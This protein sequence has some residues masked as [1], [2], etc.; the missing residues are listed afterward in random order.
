[1]Y[2]SK[3]YFFWSLLTLVV[4]FILHIG[5]FFHGKIPA[6]YKKIIDIL[7]YFRTF[8]KVTLRVI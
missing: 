8:V 3:Y 2:D 6:L 7:T 1:M 4:S 5:N